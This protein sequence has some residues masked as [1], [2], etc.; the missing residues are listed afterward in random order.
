MSAFQ[1]AI[2]VSLYRASPFVKW[3]L[4]AAPFFHQNRRCATKITWYGNLYN[5]S[6]LL[7]PSSGVSGFVPISVSALGPG[8]TPTRMLTPDDQSL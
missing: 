5:L 6:D 1:E 7:C 8:N 2:L 3:P 4:S